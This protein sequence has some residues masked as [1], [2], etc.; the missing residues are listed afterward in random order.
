MTFDLLTITAEEDELSFHAGSLTLED[1]RC[2]SL[3]A[4]GWWPCPCADPDCHGGSFSFDL[5]WLGHLLFGG[6]R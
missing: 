1:G 2:F 6:A 5:F 4:L 3:L